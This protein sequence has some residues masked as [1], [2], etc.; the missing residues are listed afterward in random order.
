MSRKASTKPPTRVKGSAKPEPA[1]KLGVFRLPPSPVVTP[2]KVAAEVVIDVATV[3]CPKCGGA[4][5]DNREG[6]RNPKAPD[7]KCRTRTC[8][9]VIWPR[10]NVRYVEAQREL[11]P[12]APL[13]PP[14]DAAVAE[15]QEQPLQWA[16][17]SIRQAVDSKTPGTYWSHLLSGD[18]RVAYALATVVDR[19]GTQRLLHWGVAWTYPHSAFSQIH[20]G[21]ESGVYCRLC[22]RSDCDGATFAK[23]TL[24]R[25]PE[26]WQ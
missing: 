16:R 3:R 2:S 18:G 15:A 20:N 21:E 8:E 9:G 10:A 6:K 5:W 23:R 13:Q 25:G 17:E 19:E 12:V 24:E 14:P 1:K 22:Q 26:L 7:F 4:L 11:Q